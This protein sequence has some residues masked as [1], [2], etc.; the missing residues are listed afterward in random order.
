M[1]GESLSS[2]IYRIASANYYDSVLPLRDHLSLTLSQIKNN[3]YDNKAVEV[4]S[5]LLNISKEDLDSMIVKSFRKDICTKFIIRNRIKYCPLCIKEKIYH[6]VKWCLVPI[7]ICFT[8]SVFLLDDCFN[9]GNNVDMD[10]FLKGKCR[11]CE[12]PYQRANPIYVKE[13]SLLFLSQ[14]N[15]YFRLIHMKDSSIQ[16]P[17]LSFEEYLILAS[18]SF[19]ILEGLRTFQDEQQFIEIFCNKKNRQYNNKTVSKAFEIVYWMY[20]DFPN[21]FFRVLDTFKNKPTQIMY[22][23]KVHFEQLFQMKEFHVIEKE[24]N[25]YWLQQLNNGAIRKDF[26]IFARKLSLLEQREYISKEEVKQVYGIPYSHIDKLISEGKVHANTIT[27]GSLKGYMIKKESLE[28]FLEMYMNIKE[29]ALTLGFQR[30]SIGKLIRAGVL[31]TGKPYM[32]NQC[33]ILKNDVEDL[34][35]VSR[36]GFQNDECEGILFHAA[37]TKYNTNGL[38][39]VNLIR[40]LKEQQIRTMTN[41]VDGNFK[42]CY[43]HIGD[44][45]QWNE[46]EKMKQQQ[47]Q[48]YFMTDVLDLLH[49]G[50]KKMW[51]II[52]A[53]ILLPDNTKVI[54][55]GKK[56]YLFR[57]DKVEQF[58]E[59]YASIKQAAQEFNIS[60][61][62]LR[63]WLREGKLTDVWNG[64]CRDY[65]IKKEELRLLLTNAPK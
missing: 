31:N 10:S 54:K 51:K 25:G 19:H 32:A 8:H 50:E 18:Y 38:T 39:L 9:C 44:L 3:Q 12:H 61:N 36:I 57:K 30:D 27:R 16:F 46:K 56:Q 23:Q 60:P 52:E 34:L 43:L 33:L 6:Q 42:D 13:G 22:E 37:L 24:Y 64:K 48:G 65:L 21:N 11:I 4:L 49:I 58:I 26:S 35:D 55:S 20:D 47:V 59:E 45:L 15:L 28:S 17:D 14:K 1:Y 41:K 62:I 5:E 53:G 7:S 63:K 29:A 40:L 2:Y